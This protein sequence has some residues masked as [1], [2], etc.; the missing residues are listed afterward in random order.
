MAS[1]SIAEVRTIPPFYAGKLKAAGIKSTTKLLA[2][3][4][5]PRLRKALSESTEIPTPLILDW[6]NIADLTRVS[7]IA[8]E[9]AELLVAAGVDTVKDLSR[10]NA[11][12]LVARMTEINRRKQRVRVLPTEKRVTQWIGKAKKL[13]PGMDY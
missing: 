9:Y 2:R 11:A 10:R 8:I 4:A 3:A 7:G 12:N 13:S 1:Y 5:T 6:A